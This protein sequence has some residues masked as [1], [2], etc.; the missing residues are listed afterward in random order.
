MRV[1]EVESY[2]DHVSRADVID[3]VRESLTNIAN[4]HNTTVDELVDG[5]RSAGS[6]GAPYQIRAL[7]LQTRLDRLER[8]DS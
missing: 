7:N 4:K 5:A 8:S 2:S 3:K 1:V 6:L